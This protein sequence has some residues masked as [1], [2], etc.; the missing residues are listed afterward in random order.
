MGRAGSPGCG[1]TST[2]GI[3]GTLTGDCAPEGMGQVVRIV[4]N[5]VPNFGGSNTHTFAIVVH[6]GRYRFG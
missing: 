4:W 6:G 1:E 5:A 3:G 2:R